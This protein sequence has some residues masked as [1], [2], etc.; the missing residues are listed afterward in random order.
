[1]LVVA[2]LVGIILVLL[3]VPVAV[4]LVQDQVVM[5]HQELNPLVAEEVEVLEAHQEEWVVLVDL[6]LL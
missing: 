4:V 3:V 1:M 2:V 6:V 5:A